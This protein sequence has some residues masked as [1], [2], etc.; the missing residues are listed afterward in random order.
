MIRSLPLL[1]ILAMLALATPR[2]TAQDGSVRELVGAITLE[3]LIDLPGWF[4]EEFLTWAPNMTVAAEIPARMRDVQL[5][6]VL[7][8]WCGDSRREVPR[9][10][11]LLQL[12]G[13][14]PSVLS[15]YGV[16]R[17]KRSPDGHE[18]R[19]GIE[20]VPTIIVL[21]GDTEIGRITESPTRSLEADLLG[22]LDPSTLPPPP[23]S[24]PPAP[25]HTE[26]PP[27]HEQP[28]E[29]VSPDGTVQGGGDADRMPADLAPAADP[30]TPPADQRK[31]AAAPAEKKTDKKKGRTK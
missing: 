28:A 20:R 26:E 13:L 24:V 12:T 19:W 11:R 31:P 16:D 1:L 25:E 2:A 8:T 14:D 6:C 22:I 23:P 30:A 17:A 27:A 29:H 7:G 4:G 21:R 15:M 5:V 18:R 10:L 3:Q 9:L